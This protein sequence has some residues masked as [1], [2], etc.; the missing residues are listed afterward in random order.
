[1]TL[2]LLIAANHAVAQSAK[3][4]VGTWTLTSA[5]AFGPNPKGSI[6]FDANGRFSAILMRN[7]LPKYASNNRTQATPAEHKATVDG[8][9]A[10][11][12]TYSVTGTDLNLRM[13]GSTYPNR[14]GNDQKRINMSITGDEL[15][16]AEH[17]VLVGMNTDVN[18]AGNRQAGSS[19][20]QV[21]AGEMNGG[22]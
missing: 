5:D 12:G 22:Q 21:L 7:N 6:M 8:S 3:D 11:F 1:M 18:P 17:Q 20:F 9:L 13:E 16:G 2:G 15:P 14:T 10:Y 19:L 4:L